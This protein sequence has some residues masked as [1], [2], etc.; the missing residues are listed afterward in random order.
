MIRPYLVGLLPGVL[1]LQAGRVDCPDLVNRL[2]PTGAA[3]MPKVLVIDDDTEV[4]ALICAILQRG[5]GYET[6]QANT[7]L[8]G[9][10]AFVLADFDAVVTDLIMPGQNGVET[11]KKIRAL[12]SD[13]PIIAV[14]GFGWDESSDLVRDALMAGANRSLGKPFRDNE[15]LSAMIAL[16]PR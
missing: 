1:W 3:P 7:G 14:S 11:I 13:V 4:R 6:V 15:L 9:L 12:D 16:I 10:D 5:G 8:A 2:H